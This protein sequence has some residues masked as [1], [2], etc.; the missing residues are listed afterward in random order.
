MADSS[1]PR[2]PWKLGFSVSVCLF[3][4]MW[5]QPHGCKMA[6]GSW[7][8]EFIAETERSRKAKRDMP[9]VFAPSRS[10][11][12]FCYLFVQGRLADV[13]CISP[14]CYPTPVLPGLS[15]SERTQGSWSPLWVSEGASA[16]AAAPNSHCG[17]ELVTEVVFWH[18]GTST[19]LLLVA[20]CSS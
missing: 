6:P 20:D 9:A 17:Y 15:Y 13:V 3:F 4:C 16:P 7:Y 19:L 5:L 11:H 12:E 18:H 14:A 2:C 8:I 10:L 1:G